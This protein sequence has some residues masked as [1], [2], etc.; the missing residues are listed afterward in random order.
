MEILYELELVRVVVDAPQA[1]RIGLDVGFMRQ[2][3]HRET[4]EFAN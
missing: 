3:D 2:A 1:A 4:R